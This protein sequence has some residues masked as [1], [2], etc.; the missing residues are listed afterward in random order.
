MLAD[1]DPDL[2]KVRA[3]AAKLSHFHWSLKPP[4]LCVL[5]DGS[6]LGKIAYD[7][8]AA[9]NLAWTYHRPKTFA[10]HNTAIVT[11][12]MLRVPLTKKYG[13]SSLTL[14]DAVMLLSKNAFLHWVT[15]YRAG[16]DNA[17]ADLL[18]QAGLNRD[19]F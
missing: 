16:M 2:A 3:L 5:P 1:A 15:L 18:V 7:N 13:S 14:E 17:L 19:N 12:V 6:G 4:E 11:S 10:E 9:F 8:M